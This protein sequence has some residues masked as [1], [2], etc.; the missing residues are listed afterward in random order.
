LQIAQPLYR[1]PVRQP[2]AVAI[3]C[4]AL[5]PRSANFVPAMAMSDVGKLLPSTPREPYSTDQQRQVA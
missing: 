4:K 2:R 5:I 1:A 3:R